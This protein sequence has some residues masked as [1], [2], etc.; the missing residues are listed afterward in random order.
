[1]VEEFRS[2][3]KK[4]AFSSAQ[5]NSLSGLISFGVRVDREHQMIAVEAAFSTYIKPAELFSIADSIKNSYKL[6]RVDIYPRFEGV[7]FKP[8]YMDGIIDTL[9]RFSRLD[10]GFFDNSVY[11]YDEEI[12]KFVIKLRRGIS[13][14]YLET[15]G[16]EQFIIQ[17]VSQQFGVSLDL[18]LEGDEVV[19]AEYFNDR[20]DVLAESIR[21]Q[22]AAIA[23]ETVKPDILN[24]L[25]AKEYC[26]PECAITNRSASAEN[27]SR[28]RAKKITRAI[29][30]PIPFI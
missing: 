20:E 21:N 14:E 13:V 29:R 16:A 6:N 15:N 12:S 30:S 23:A 2:K 28:S 3:F 9:K 19:P 27:C 26:D 22:R 4:A 25:N 24:S 18:V 10:Y 7:A 8:E 5:I 17:C 1:M 11:N